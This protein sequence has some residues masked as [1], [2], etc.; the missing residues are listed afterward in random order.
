MIPEAAIRSKARSQ[1]WRIRGRK[2]A[3][4]AGIKNIITQDRTRK[5]V[6][7]KVTPARK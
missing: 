1:L 3:V 5:T 2:N 6:L 7:S 4:E